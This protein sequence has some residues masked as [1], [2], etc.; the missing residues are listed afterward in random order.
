MCTV[1]LNYLRVGD[2]FKI[3]SAHTPGQ[4]SPH[5][6]MLPASLLLCYRQQMKD[7]KVINS[8]F[9]FLNDG[10]NKSLEDVTALGCFVVSHNK[11]Y[12]ETGVLPGLT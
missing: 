4:G 11:I 10:G 8:I 12:C 5:S 6:I 3:S 9:L 7:Y 1:I 2:G